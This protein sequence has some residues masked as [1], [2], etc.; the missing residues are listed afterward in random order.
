MDDF[1]NWL[2]GLASGA[3]GAAA[4]GVLLVVVNPGTFDIY[5][6][7]GWK[8]IGTACGASAL[9]AVCG[10]LKQSPLPAKRIETSTTQTVT[11]DV[12]KKDNLDG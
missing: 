10:Y 3:I 12:I 8:N 6:S 7:A 11:K 4:S 5:S 2:Y 1:K 9:V